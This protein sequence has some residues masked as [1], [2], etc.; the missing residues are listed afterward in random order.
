MMT[1][2]LDGMPLTKTLLCQG[3]WDQMHMPIPIRGPLA[4]PLRLAGIRVSRMHP[5]LCTICETQFKRVKG[6][7]QMLVPA[8][9]LFADVRGYTDLSER[10][11]AA[12]MAGLLS[13]F[14]EHCATSIWERDGVVNKLIGDS[15]FAI[16]N[17]PIR[18]N[19]HPRR[20]VE[21]GLELQ[22]R[23]RVIQAV[24][25]RTGS[26]AVG[27]GVGIH[28]GEITIG[29]VGQFCRDFTAIGPIINQA[30]RLQGA[31]R[32][33]E[34]LVSADAYDH[35]GAGVGAQGPRQLQ[36]KGI[37]RPVTAYA[38]QALDA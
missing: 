12:Q 25:Q 22:R 21:A 11:D 37:D 33:G 5:N 31:A 15:V 24:S 1:K 28:T 2:G 14:Y 7:Q 36:L 38:V 35:L 6:A 26:D 34:V 10:L 30:A 17:F 23:W 9:V 27:V 4:V 20:A 29:E 19:D 8:T 16:F 13:T 18:H 3:C 32:P